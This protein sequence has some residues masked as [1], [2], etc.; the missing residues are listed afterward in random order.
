[1]NSS[2]KILDRIISWGLITLVF[3]IPLFFLPI[4]ANFYSFNKNFLLYLVV[5]LLLIVWGIKIA[6]EKKIKIT[7][8]PFNLLIILFALSQIVALIF[9]SSNKVEPLVFDMSTGTILALTLLYF[10]I[11]NYS[12]SVGSISVA[13]IASATLLGLIAIFQ[14]VGLGENLNFPDW[15]S[16]K[17]WTPAGAPL[18][19]VSFLLV[20]FV[21]ALTSFLKKFNRS[22]SSGLGYGLATVLIS[23]GLIVTLFQILPGGENTPLILPYSNAWAIAIEAFKQNPLW[24]VGPGNFVS[25]FNRFRPISFNQNEFWNVRFDTSSNY[26]LHLLTVSG[27]IGLITFVWLTLKILKS[28]KKITKNSL[29]LSIFISLLLLFFLPFNFLI[30]FVFFVLLSLWAAQKAEKEEVTQSIPGKWAL[31]PLALIVLLAGVTFYFGG[32]AYLAEV[33]FRRS[34]VALSQNRGIEVYN[35]QIKAIELNPRIT[36]YRIAYSQTNFALANSLA[37]QADLSDQERANISQLIQ[38]AIREAKLATVLNPTRADT[39][40]NLGQLYRNLINFAQD[41]D[42]W[43][44]VALQEA[45]R[46]D[47][48]SPRI[49]L[50]LGGL[51]YGLKNYEAASRHFENAVD[52]K[53]DYANGFY[54]LAAA[55]RE[56]EKYLQAH[57]AMQIVLN[58]LPL[59]SPDYQKAKEELD[60]L[61]KKLPSTQATPSVQ[62]QIQ[63][64]EVLTEPESLPSPALEPPLEL[65]EEAAP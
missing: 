27:V 22:V 15:M 23:L 9:A 49:R 5:L 39:W 25:A 36:N 50:N 47:P 56:Q 37:Q 1:M 2:T 46:T 34:L 18:S 14:F 51:F 8:S 6:V 20:A 63:P 53:P 7:R 12:W 16:L 26:L 62:P 45:I 57:Q 61:A 38:Q 59:N 32:R 40:E 11:V 21:L 29:Y 10:L 19:L 13:A 43:A 17:L 35:Y 33:Y 60:E 44:I 28:A 30:L 55:Y 24:G 64:E 3:L 42:Q 52:L 41:A 65:P 4:T 31:V 48:I 58:L 54:N